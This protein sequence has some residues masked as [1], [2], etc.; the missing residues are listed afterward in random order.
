[1]QQG[2]QGRAKGRQG[3]EHERSRQPVETASR[4]SKEGQKDDRGRKMRGAETASRDSQQRQQGRAKAR[5][6]KENERSL[7]SQLIIV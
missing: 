6:G 2:D 5:Q 1:M 7:D 3:T 4:D